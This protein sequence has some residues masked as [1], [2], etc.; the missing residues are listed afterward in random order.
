MEDITSSSG[1]SHT[2]YFGNEVETDLNNDG[3]LDKIFLLTQQQSDEIFT[4]VVAALN[5]DNGYTRSQAVHIDEGIAPQ[6][7]EL[8]SGN[9]IIVNYTIP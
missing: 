9:T 8:R 3:K 6:T 1:Y 4:Y 7:T 2:D 5:T